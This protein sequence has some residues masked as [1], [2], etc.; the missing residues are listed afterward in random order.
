MLISENEEKLAWQTN[1]M[2]E[3]ESRIIIKAASAAII[4]NA[5]L[6]KLFLQK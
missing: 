4:F 6:L 1:T 3:I 5:T 2:S